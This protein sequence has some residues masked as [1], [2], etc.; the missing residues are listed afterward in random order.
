MRSLRSFKPRIIHLR[1]YKI[2]TAR[3]K[4]VVK[5]TEETVKDFTWTRKMKA[6]CKAQ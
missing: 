3:K 6:Q 1:Q 4:S 5:F 2:A